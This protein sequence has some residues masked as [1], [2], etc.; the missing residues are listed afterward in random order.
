MKRVYFE[1]TVED[2]EVVKLQKLLLRAANE[3]E[4]A[5]SIII[6]VEEPKVLS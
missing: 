4:T 3:T 2:Y 1:A 6:Y 5:R